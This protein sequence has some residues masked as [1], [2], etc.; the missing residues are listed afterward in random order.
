MSVLSALRVLQVLD[1][2]QILLVNEDIKIGNVKRLCPSVNMKA[3]S[4]LEKMGNNAAELEIHCSDKAGEPASSRDK[5]DWKCKA[6]E[7][8]K[9]KQDTFWII[10]STWGKFPIYLQMDFRWTIGDLGTWC[11][12]PGNRQLSIVEYPWPQ[13]RETFTDAAPLTCF[14]KMIII[15]A[16][17]LWGDE[18]LCT[19]VK[20]V[21]IQT[22]FLG[23]TVVINRKALTMFIPL[24]SVIPF[25][26][27]YFIVTSKHALVNSMFRDIHRNFI[28]NHTA[29]YKKYSK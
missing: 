6:I 11:I 9:R 13:T 2:G 23:S 14:L 16:R 27:K 25:L 12:T 28:Y 5:L 26:T 7:E 17:E 4:Y 10:W 15:H 24:V 29:K 22:I 8:G 21:K 18:H 19:Q 20:E 3:L 1:F